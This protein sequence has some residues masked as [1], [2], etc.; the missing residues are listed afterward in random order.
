MFNL[1]LKTVGWAEKGR[2]QLGE[3]SFQGGKTGLFKKRRARL[4]RARQP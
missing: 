2:Y 4:W 1:L 3:S